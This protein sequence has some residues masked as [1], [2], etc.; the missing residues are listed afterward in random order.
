[1]TERSQTRKAKMKYALIQTKTVVQLARIVQLGRGARRGVLKSFKTAVA[2]A[3]AKRRRYLALEVLLEARTQ[4]NI[5]SLRA[6]VGTANRSFANLQ[7]N[8]NARIASLETEVETANRLVAILQTSNARIA[9]LQ[10]EVETANRLVAN[11]QTNLE[12]SLDNESI[13]SRIAKLANSL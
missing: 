12:E 10:A 13:A 8:S 2:R 4:A 7:T 3:A 11:L 1:M 6:D 5:A 9:S